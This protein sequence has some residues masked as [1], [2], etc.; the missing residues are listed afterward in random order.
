VKQL[1]H[2]I[3]RVW[4][5][6]DDGA[7]FGAKADLPVRGGIRAAAALDL[8]LYSIP[9]RVETTCPLSRLVGTQSI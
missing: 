6:W 4:L 9:T 5:F 7:H 1:R 8:G 3:E 2:E